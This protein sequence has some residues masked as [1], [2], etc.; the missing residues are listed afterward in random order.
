MP[1]T[2]QSGV[3]RTVR[4]T[5]RATRRSRVFSGYVG[6]KS[7]DSPREAPDS[8][9]LQPCNDYLPRRQE[10]TVIWR[11]GRSG[12][13]QKRKPAIQG[14]LCHVLCSYCSL[15]GVHRTVPCTYEQKA[16]ITYQMELQQL[17]AA[18]GL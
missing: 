13:P 17:L 3:H 7:P 9:V 6:Y 15:S 16:R 1:F 10:P 8:L 11:T 12:A 2:G 4:C 5:V 18:L 14:I